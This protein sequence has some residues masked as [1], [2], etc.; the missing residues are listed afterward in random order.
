MGFHVEVDVWGVNG[1]LLLGHDKPGEEDVMPHSM[2][3]YHC[4]NMAAADLMYGSNLN[5][6]I[7][8]NDF[9]GLT[10]KGRIWTN[11]PVLNGKCISVLPERFTE[12]DIE[13]YEIDLSKA[14]GI[15]TDYPLKYQKLYE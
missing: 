8:H 7:H 10:S 1:K 12:K 4:K 15:C 5:Y 9:A 6:F 13:L 11:R 2:I 14:Y 3:Y